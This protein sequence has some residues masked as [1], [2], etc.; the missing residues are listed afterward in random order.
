[1]DTANLTGAAPVRSVADLQP[2]AV[3]WGAIIA[4]AVAAAAASIVLLSLGAGIGLTSVSPWNGE[5]VSAKALGWTA[6]VWMIVMQWLSAALGGYLT[7]R[8][9]TR[10]NLH[11]DEV[12]FRDTA[13][14]FLS[15]AFAIVII[16]L[17]AS[18]AVVS[19]LGGA[20]HGA[21]AGAAAASRNDSTVNSSVDMLF[22][23]GNPAPNASSD[24]VRGETARLLTRSLAQGQLN[25]DDRAYLT[26]VVAARTGLSQTDAQQRVDQVI[27]QT[28]EAADAARKAAAA[29]AI[30]TALSLAI[31]AFIAA[32]A[33]GIGGRERDT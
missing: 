21:A 13:H 4:G 2:S 5:G 24:E 19:T 30:A 28:K 20:A 33:G 11:T 25:A 26:G 18:S 27:A 1:M 32:V 29:L 7:G 14:G 17:V 8:L 10:W 6:I 15:W 3:A 31:G 16:S 22:R 9:R 23:S 12:Y